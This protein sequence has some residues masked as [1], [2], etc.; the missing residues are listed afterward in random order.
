MTSELERELR[1]RMIDATILCKR[2]LGWNPT[3]AV[4]MI[5]EQ[6]A[7]EAAR[8]MVMLPDGSSGFAR[9]WENNRLDL[10]VESIIL[11]AKF[12]PLFTADVLN[13]AR[14]RLEEARSR[15]PK[16]A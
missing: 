14:N 5:R 16:R 8:R 3:A 13:I 6:G 7:A 2:D 1:G 4:E 11:D 9:C 15:P 10:A 12:A